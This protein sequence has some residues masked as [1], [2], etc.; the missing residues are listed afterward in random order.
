[1]TEIQMKDLMDI[2]YP[3]II[4][5]RKGG[6]VVVVIE[7]LTLHASASTLDGA[8]EELDKK[9]TI[10]FED[11]IDDDLGHSL[12]PPQSTRQQRSATDSHGRL[13][14]SRFNRIFASFCLGGFLLLGAYAVI[15]IPRVIDNIPNLANRVIENTI[16]TI[17]SKTGSIVRG[18]GL[19]LILTRL[20]VRLKELSPERREQYLSELASIVTEL[21]PFVDE[22]SPLFCSPEK[23]LR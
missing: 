23:D 1:M 16:N 9:K 8:L 7:E 15:S 22:V 18:E 19:G 21:Q 12:P 11:L 2:D 17:T 10:L 20:Q 13:F 5:R 14:D 4:R 3:I 6:K